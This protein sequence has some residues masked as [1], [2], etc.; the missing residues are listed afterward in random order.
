MDRHL[1]RS[2]K[3]LSRHVRPMCSVTG[4]PCGAVWF[5]LALKNKNKPLDKNLR[6]MATA[7]FTISL[8]TYF[9]KKY[10]PIY[11]DE[12]FEKCDLLSHLNNTKTVSKTSLL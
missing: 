4:L 5:K 3:H 12:D 6:E 8:D 2:V 9:N 1:L 11:S 10:P 7:E